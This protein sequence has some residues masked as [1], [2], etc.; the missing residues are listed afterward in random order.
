MK[1][2]AK[3]ASDLDKDTQVSKKLNH[4]L[5]SFFCLFSSF[6][7]FFISYSTIPIFSPG[8]AGCSQL[9]SINKRI[10]ERHQYNCDKQMGHSDQLI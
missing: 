4:I 6:L 1:A 7:F 10:T 5:F 9:I 8:L 3:N 2:G